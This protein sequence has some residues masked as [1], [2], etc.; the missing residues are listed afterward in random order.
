MPFV[1]QEL[2]LLIIITIVLIAVIILSDREGH[3]KKSRTDEHRKRVEKTENTIDN[4]GGLS[5]R[6]FVILGSVV[7]VL[8][9]SFI[10]AKVIPKIGDALVEGILQ[11]L[12]ESC[13]GPGHHE[14]S[15]AALLTRISAN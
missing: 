7:L 1:M 5:K 12:F 4:V 15:C 14:Y 13:A 3:D 11:S 2:L 9:F 6:I 10:T 8:A